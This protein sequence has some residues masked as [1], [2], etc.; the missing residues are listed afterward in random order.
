MPQWLSVKRLDVEFLPFEI[1][2]KCKDSGKIYL[3]GRLERGIIPK[4]CVW[5]HGDGEGEDGFVISLQKMNLE[6]FQK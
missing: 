5:M 4:E 6:L 2:V 1:N 3:G